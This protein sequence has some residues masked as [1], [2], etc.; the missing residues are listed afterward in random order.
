MKTPQHRAFTLIELLVVISIIALL[1]GL[2]LPALGAARAVGRSAAC[3]SNLKQIGLSANIYA[4][5]Y[6]DALPI[7]G[8][9][10]SGGIGLSWRSQLSDYMPTTRGEGPKEIDCPQAIADG[11]P[12]ERTGTLETYGYNRRLGWQ[13]ADGWNGYRIDGVPYG[14]F[15]NDLVPAG[16]PA[17]SMTTVPLA[18]DIEAGPSALTP[19]LGDTNGNSFAGK[20]ANRHSG[21]MNFAMVGGSAKTVKLDDDLEEET[22]KDKTLLDWEELGVSWVETFAPDY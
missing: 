19:W 10:L 13:I 2:L 22:L 11:F 21:G 16:I 1:I 3:L 4:N 15:A 8:D 17:G 5:D 20:Y 12:P 14:Q 7:Q 9:T 6:K 18:F